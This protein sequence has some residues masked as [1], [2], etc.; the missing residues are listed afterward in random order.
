MDIEYYKMISVILPTLWKLQFENQLKLLHD[1]EL[2]K[3]IILINNDTSATPEWVSSKK[4]KKILEVRPYSN[5]FVNPSWN[6][7]ARMASEE[8]IMILNDDIVTKSYDFLSLINDT[9]N[10]EDCIIGIGKNSY[11]DNN[12]NI[13]LEDITNR[14]RDLGF[15]CM[16]FLNKKYYKEIPSKYLIWRGDDFLIDLH[17]NKNMKV[18]NINGLSMKETKMST[19]VDLP[20]FSWKE[21]EFLGYDEALQEYLK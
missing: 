20:E 1:N 13:H 11:E 10:I 19:T 15:G 16:I 8:K 18:Y 17:K 6:L 21:R 7:G 5:I 2:I 12:Q 14:P 9:L 4:Y 3:E